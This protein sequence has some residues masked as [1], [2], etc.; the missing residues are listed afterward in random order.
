VRAGDL[1]LDKMKDP[2]AAERHYREATQL[3]ATNWSAALGLAHV[4]EQRGDR[5]AAAAIYK[6]ILVA[7][8]ATP[9]LYERMLA[10]FRLKQLTK[11]ARRSDAGVFRHAF[12]PGITGGRGSPDGLKRVA[13]VIGQ[14]DYL[15]LASLPNPR[16][17]SAVMANALTEMGF[18]VVEI[19]EN[20]G[21][22]ELRSV[23]A[24]IAERAA[25]A[26][27][28]LVFYA[29]H[30]VEAN[31]INYLIPVDAAPESDRD[32]QNGALALS[33]LVAAGAK[34]R[35]GSLIIVDACRDD[36][37]VEARAVAAASR[38]AARGRDQLP[39]VRLHSGLATITNVA[40]N[41]VVFYSTQPGQVALDGEGLDSPFVRAL[42]ETLAT[43]NQPFQ[44]VV[45][46]TTKSVIEKTRGL[47][48]PAAYGVSPAIALLPPAS[49]R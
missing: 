10:S 12:D 19:A 3:A 11:P 41:G 21:A 32:L 28:V 42:L 16:R 8:E 14:G 13:F 27:I 18:D 38:H 20:L 1:A 44:A 23:P 43:P 33:G 48:E 29:G 17:D 4:A 7:T 46:S 30:G 2:A 40:P 26:D 31:G 35:R 5:P 49:T 39:P 34:A 22:S 6:R 15:K 24:S 37:F 25:Q 9:K 36:P 45:R 47:Q